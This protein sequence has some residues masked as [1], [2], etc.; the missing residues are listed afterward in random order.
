VTPAQSPSLSPRKK[1]VKTCR[2]CGEA[3][4]SS[5]FRRNAR[6]RDGL[7]SWCHSEAKRGYRRK[8]RAEALLA[9]AAE[10]E[11]QAT[12]TTGWQGRLAQSAADA[13]RRQAER[14]MVA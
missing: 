7:S 14:E 10:L 13:V 8:Q 11:R 12:A 3:K 2:R 6:T 5:E 9:E 4:D 1:S